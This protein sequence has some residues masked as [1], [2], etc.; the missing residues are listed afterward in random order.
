MK[1]K[2]VLA[3]LIVIILMGFASAWTFNGT[4]RNVDG[5]FINNTLVNITF[6]TMGGPTGLSAVGSNSTF[7]NASGWFSLN[8][9]ENVSWMYKPV[10][11]NTNITT[12]ATDYIGQS[13]PAFPYMEF[14]NTTGINFYLKPAGKINITALGSNGSRIFFRYQIKDT[15]LGYPIAEQFNTVVLESVI[16]IARDRNYSIMIYPD[17][18]LPVSLDWNNFTS[19]S[20]YTIVEGLSTYNITT[21]TVQKQFNCTDNLI[22]LTGYIN[23]ST[24][25]GNITGWDEFK[26]VPYLLEPGNMIYLGDNAG[27]PYNMSAWQTNASGANRLYSDFYNLTS[28]FYNITLPGPAESA[29]YILFATARNGT[30]YYGGYKNITLTYSSSPTWL[31]FTMY[32]LM[33]SNWGSVNSNISLND[34]V[35]WSKVNISSAKQQFNFINSSNAIISNVN[36]HLEIKVD[37]TDYG[38]KE[39][40]FMTDIS[41]GNASFY[42]PLLNASVKEMNIFSQSYSPKRVGTKTA[43][44]ILANPNTTMTTFNPSDISGTVSK[45]NI[46]IALYKSNSTCDVPSPDSSCIIA[47]SAS[48]DPDAEDKFNPLSSIIGGGK[49]SFRMGLLS[50]GIIVE[51]IN[52]DM[53]A[54][55]PPDALFDDSATTSTSDG[56]D[57]AM[58]FGSNGPN[59]YDYVLISMPYT[60]G[61]TSITGL[62][63]TADVNMSIPLL[64]DEDWNIIWNSSSNGTSGTTLAGNYSHYSTYSSQWETL[65]GQNICTKNQSGLNLTNPCYIDTTNNRIWIR[66]PH[67][68][69]TKPNVVGNLISAVT[70]AAVT[71]PSSSSST[72]GTPSFWTKGTIEVT[73]SQFKKGYSTELAQRQRVKISIDGIEHHIGIIDLTKNTATINV[74]SVPQQAVF[75][76]GDEKKFEV[77]EDNYYDVYVKLNGIDNNKANVTIMSIHEKMSEE[78]VGGIIGGIKNIASSS[79]KILIFALIGI[80][81]IILVIVFSKNKKKKRR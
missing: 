25:A 5:N 30:K 70:A 58:R 2:I 44:E 24:I 73:E 19:N 4:I 67:F 60:E 76:I 14:V 31:N 45:A 11:T 71:S 28:G 29:T 66:L 63:E 51:Y 21:H 35:A 16:S 61:S 34:A 65:M 49:L 42:L 38:A 8:V 23:T 74:S 32:S 77:T 56:F 33:S 20:S 52:V 37:Y 48:M 46:Q 26:I 47:D 72:P 59:I 75:N 12:N 22:R 39:F 78:E 43:A 1:L 18:S 55:G 79:N 15:K 7:S 10:I 57:S 81:I 3:F 27:M 13:L 9:S 54:S 6:W 41:S 80:V 69:G 53:L 50:S 40:T 36:F 17:Q 64:Y 62:N 68:S